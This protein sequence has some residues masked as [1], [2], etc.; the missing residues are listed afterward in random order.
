MEQFAWSA[1]NFQP[2]ANHQAIS[3]LCL[4]YY[5]Y[6]SFWS[7]VLTGF[8]SA[9][10]KTLWCTQFLPSAVHLPSKASYWTMCPIFLFRL[11]NTLELSSCASSPHLI[12]TS[13]QQFKQNINWTNLIQPFHLSILGVP[14]LSGITHKNK[15][16]M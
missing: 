3:S 2:L 14:F 4:F 5:Y 6:N 12:T 7:L 9:Q 13:L 11:Y 10:P 16:F 8:I 15:I 1:N